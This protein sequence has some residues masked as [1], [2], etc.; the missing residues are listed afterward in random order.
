MNRIISSTPKH[1]LVLALAL[2]ALS[3]AN[4][5]AQVSPLRSAAPLP[6]ADSTIILRLDFAYGKGLQKEQAGK[7]PRI[8]SASARLVMQQFG[9]IDSDVSAFMPGFN[10][11]DTILYHPDGYSYRAPNY[12]HSVVMQYKQ[13]SRKMELVNALS[14]ISEIYSVREIL[15]IQPLEE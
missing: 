12:A 10:E 4:L 14:A 8:T 9:V 2:L 11:A 1:F 7:R 13:A 6:N 15:K 5:A 3:A